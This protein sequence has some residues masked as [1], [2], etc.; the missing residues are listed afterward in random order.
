MGGL[1]RQV[2]WDFPRVA[3]QG[4]GKSADME[5]LGQPVQPTVTPYSE[6]FTQVP[7]LPDGKKYLLGDSQASGDTV[8]A[9]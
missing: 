1:E 2:G 8:P 5:R 4:L 7:R 6:A 9:A 3:Q